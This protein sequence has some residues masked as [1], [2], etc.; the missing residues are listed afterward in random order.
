MPLTRSRSQSA[1]SSQPAHLFSGF[2][3]WRRRR[4]SNSVPTSPLATSSSAT[5]A[6]LSRSSSHHSDPPNQLYHQQEGVD[7]TDDETVTH[8]LSPEDASSQHNLH[9]RLLPNIGLN[10]RCFVFDIIDRVLTPTTVLKVGRY[11]ER[12]ST[13]DRVCF[14]SKVVSRTHAELWIDKDRKVSVSPPLSPSA[15]PDPSSIDLHPRCRLI[16]WH[17]CQS[18]T[19][20][21]IQWN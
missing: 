4:M 9:I 11:S 13:H 20:I 5:T 3:H 15:W 17:L 21:G 14:K 18:A 2:Q 16:Q 10:S 19:T 8:A 7:Q 6:E 1:S 12:H